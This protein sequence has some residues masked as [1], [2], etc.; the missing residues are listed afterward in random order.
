MVESEWMSLNCFYLELDNQLEAA[1]YDD[2]A[3]QEAVQF[4]L[5]SKI[6]EKGD[7]VIELRR[8]A[9]LQMVKKLDSSSKEGVT[10]AGKEGGSALKLKGLTAP[11]FTGKAEDFASCKERFL[12]LVL[13]GRS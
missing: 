10:V 4:D 11:T 13:K 3:V 8:L 12:A 2:K 5:S 1:E 7:V 9:E 6:K